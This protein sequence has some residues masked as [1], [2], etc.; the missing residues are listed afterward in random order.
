MLILL[1]KVKK[2][3]DKDIKH[4]MMG[5]KKGKFIHKKAGFIHK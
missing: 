2:D 3:F 4:E 5:V 1:K